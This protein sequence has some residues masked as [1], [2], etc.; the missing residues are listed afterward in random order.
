[1]ERIAWKLGVVLAVSLLRL[2]DSILP[3]VKQIRRGGPAAGPQR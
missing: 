2:I 1:M 3:G